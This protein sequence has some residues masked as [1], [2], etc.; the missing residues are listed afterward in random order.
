MWVASLPSK[1][2]L[3]RAGLQVAGQRFQQRGLAGAVSAQNRHRSAGRRLEA[4]VEQRL[5][6]SVVGAQAFGFEQA[7]RQTWAR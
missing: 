5:A 1:L 3:P 2:T 4:Y 6:G 7:T